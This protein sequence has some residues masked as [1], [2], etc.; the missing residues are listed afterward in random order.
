MHN[1]RAFHFNEKIAICRQRI[2]RSVGTPMPS[3]DLRNFATKMLLEA[4]QQFDRPLFPSCPQK[5]Q[6]LRV[7]PDQGHH[8]PRGFAW[9][10]SALLQRRPVP[11]LLGDNCYVTARLRT[12]QSSASPSTIVV[13]ALVFSALASTAV[14]SALSAVAA[15]PRTFL[16]TLTHLLS[17]IRFADA[18]SR[19]A[20][21]AR[22]TPSE[23]FTRTAQASAC[24][25]RPSS[26]SRPPTLGGSRG[27]YPHYPP[28]LGVLRL[29][30]PIAGS[31]PDATIGQSGG[32][33]DRL[34]R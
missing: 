34:E 11:D 10:Q 4:I 15:D 23:I 6:K 28:I 12:T 25:R 16:T 29:L 30:K 8:T 33:Q 21:I 7:R 5:L 22:P 9:F 13:M 32:G 18:P 17:A 3:P 2:E 19:S 20:R 24:R 1:E 26:S 14:T 31:L 27:D